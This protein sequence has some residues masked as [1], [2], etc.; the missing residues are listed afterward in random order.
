MAAPACLA[1]IDVA[2]LAG[3]LGTRL[4]D[5]LPDRPKVLAPIG[6][7]VFLDRLLAWL[8]RFGVRRVVFCLGYRSDQVVAHLKARPPGP[9]V[10]DWIIEPAP[11]GTLGALRLALPRFASDPVL[12]LNGDTFV[13][14]DLCAFLDSHR[15]SRAAASIVGTQVDDAGRYGRI[16][17]DDAGWVRRFIEKTGIPEAGTINAGV[18]LFGRSFLDLCRDGTGASLERDVLTTRPAG[19]LHAFTGRFTFL[20]IGTSQDLARAAAFVRGLDSGRVSDA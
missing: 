19:T 10:L 8:G 1:G 4:R 7:E 6:N 16:E 20:D 17:C 2:V 18:Y 12:V 11:L 5:A 3:G 9:I 15:Q 13:D 14:V